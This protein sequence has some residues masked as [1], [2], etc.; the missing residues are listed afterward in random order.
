M[1]QRLDAASKAVRNMVLKDKVAIVTGSSRGIGW[2]I[3]RL[4]AL[5][6]AHVVLHGTVRSSSVLNSRS[7]EIK[8]LGRKALIIKGDV[9]DRA[10]V[11]NLTAR[12][13]E[14]LGRIDIL[15]NNAG[16]SPMAVIEEIAEEAWENVFKTNLTSAFLFSRAI[17]PH[18]K[19][20]RSGLILNISSGSGK[21]GGVGAHYAASKGGMNTFTRSLAFEGAPY[22]IRVNAIAPGPIESDMSEGIFSPNRKRFLESVIPLR[23]LGTSEDVANAALFLCSDDAEYITGEILEL[24]GG[25]D[26]HKPLSYPEKKYM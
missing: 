12:T 26:F 13:L 10:M 18:M 16:I 11:E 4:F 2:S 17:L 19:Q 1:I 8:T 15:V 23:R 22:G 7:R 25:L 24:D 20:R 9:G 6:G 5:E 3:A 14:E 21:S